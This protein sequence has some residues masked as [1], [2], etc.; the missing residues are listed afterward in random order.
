MR[1]TNTH[2]ERV[3]PA[4]EMAENLF[5]GSEKLTERGCPKSMGSLKNFNII[6]G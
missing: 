5:P 4:P 2:G 3:F 6:G 1:L